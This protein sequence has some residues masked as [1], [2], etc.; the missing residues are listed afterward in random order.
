MMNTF[1][2]QSCILVLLPLIPAII[3]FKIF[4]S[5]GEGAGEFWKW[6]WKFG[7]AFAGYVLLFFML[8]GAMQ[9]QLKTRDVEVWTVR[10][11]VE[12]SR[13][14]NI[15]NLIGIKSMPQTLNIE[16]D[17]SYEFKVIVGRYGD[18]LEFPRIMIDLSRVCAISR[19]IRLDDSPGTFATLQAASE[20]KVRREDA[21]RSIEVGPIPLEPIGLGS[22]VK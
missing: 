17:G 12:A 16:T 7:G 1:F 21:T 2:V 6:K 20:V 22:C 8:W 3:L 9:E 13:V 19:V 5:T 14:P 18:R 15:A 4:P 11:N 10:G